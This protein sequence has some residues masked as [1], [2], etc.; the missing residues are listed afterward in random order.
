LQAP[1]VQVGCGN[2]FTCAA[3]ADGTAWCWGAGSEGELGDGKTAF[4]S[5]PVQVSG[6]TNVIGI[7]SGQ[8]QNCAVLADG[9]ARCWGSNAGEA[10]GDGKPTEVQS[11]L[12]VVVAGVSGAKQI[13]ANEAVTMVLLADGSAAVWPRLAP[14]AGLKGATKVSAGGCALVGA[15]VECWMDGA[16]P[17]PV[18]GLP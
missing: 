5:G 6:L 15:G 11:P 16:T 3:L 17:T 18:A 2:G 9:T 13:D 1:A 10:L 8:G 4:S 7:A 12:P 14:V